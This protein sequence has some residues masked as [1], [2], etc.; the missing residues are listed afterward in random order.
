[1][2][3]AITATAHKLYKI[4]YRLLKYGEEYVDL[5]QNYYE[6]KYKERVLKNLEKR[7]KNYGFLLVS[8]AVGS[9]VLTS[10]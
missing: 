3:R 9:P 8:E 6:E 5:G 7:A 10:T 1:M 2:T 4:I